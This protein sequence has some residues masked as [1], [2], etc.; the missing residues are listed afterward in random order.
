MDKIVLDICGFCKGTGC[1]H[2]KHTGRFERINRSSDPDLCPVSEM[3]C[4]DYEDCRNKTFCHLKQEMPMETFTF[5]WLT[6]DKDIGRLNHV[7][8]GAKNE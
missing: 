2:C 5:Y 1:V 8:Q 7:T 4:E 3:P 6:G